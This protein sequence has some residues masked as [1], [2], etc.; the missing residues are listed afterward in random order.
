MTPTLGLRDAIARV[1]RAEVGT[2]DARKYWA[3]VL[4][5]SPERDYPR[6]WCGAFAMWCIN[7]GAGLQLTWASSG[8]GFI[9]TPAD[10]TH[11]P[12]P[13]DVAYFAQPFQHHAVVEQISGL[14]LFTIDGNQAGGKVAAR[15]RRT[16]DAVYYSIERFLSHA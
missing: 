16:K 13:G 6:S 15:T 9:F 7:E 14:T 3:V 5:G 1:A 12:Q 4:P 2:Q 11:D 8:R 10:I